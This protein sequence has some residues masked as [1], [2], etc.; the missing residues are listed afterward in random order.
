MT[1]ARRLLAFLFL[2]ALCSPATAQTNLTWDSGTAP[3][4]AEGN[5]DYLICTTGGS[6]N[7]RDQSL[8]TVLFTATAYEAVKPVQ[9]F[10][11]DTQER[12]INGVTY[13]FMKVQFPNRPSTNNTGWVAEGFVRLRSQCAGAPQVSAPAPTVQKWIFPTF[14]RPKLSYRT[15]ARRFGASRDGGDRLHA[16]ADLYRNDGDAVRAV[17]AGSV[18]RDRYYFYLGTYAMEVL[19]QG[20]NVV[21]YGE[22]KGRAAPNVIQGSTLKSGQVL[23]YIGTVNSGCC[24]PMLHFELFRG[25]AKGALSQPGNPYN[26]RSD[27]MDP[28]TALATWEKSTFG[29][30][31]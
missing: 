19:H 29:V 9:S 4:V 31:Y 21:R 7:V 13:T 26:R 2:V 11:T 30:S 18:I 14:Q 5:L 3:T 25:T 10:G 20:G 24:S 16:A 22:I 15:G 23:G 8:S 17:T 6:I 12:V 27:L 1:Q 28:T